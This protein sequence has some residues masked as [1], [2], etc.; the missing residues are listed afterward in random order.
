[1]TLHSTYQ[2]PA[3]VCD[4]DKLSQVAIIQELG[5]LGI[6][7]VALADSPRAIGFGSK[8]LGQRIVCPIPSYDPR[9][10]RFLVSNAPP[11][12]I[13]YSNDANAENVA[14]NAQQ[15]RSS[16]FSL[17]I[18]DS[19]TLER[20]IEKD[21][22][23]QTAL[24]CGIRVPR[25]C[26]VSSAT[27]LEARIDE[28]G[29]PLI[30]KSTNLAGGIYQFVPN[31]ESAAAVFRLMNEIIRGEALRHRE[32][33]LMAQQWV[34]QTDIRLW[35]F[36][37]CVKSGKILSFSMGERIRT[38]TRPD[39]TMGSVLLFGRTAYNPRI[40]EENRRILDHLQ[41]SGLVETEWS[42]STIDAGR[43]YL[44]DF[45]PRPSGNIR[46]ALKSGVSLAEQYYR[47]AL[48]LSPK[49]QVMRTGIVY[50]K[51]LYRQNDFLESATD[52]RVTL[53]RK[54]AVFRDDLMAAIQ[55]HRHAVDVL[56]PRDL[57][58]TWR[59]TA[60]LASILARSI[61]DG[62]HRLTDRRRW[63]LRPVKYESH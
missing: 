2:T 55:C 43:I 1:M 37:A 24:E 17:L 61:R 26:P 51:L 27:E 23:Y 6:P 58:P 50:A 45:N 47:A 31:R 4:A 22:L 7:V 36:N 57:G 40:F 25:C 16:G 32:A 63:H 62:T 3:V 15:L 56:D 21:R 34:P 48:A 18:S 35:N 33:R 41:F 38:D 10:I 14:R 28:F 59:A 49:R 39:G 13:F 5:R 11:G 9:Y 46:W 8:Y 44:Y 52:P 29:L 42:E 12:V 20:V 53:P 30:L 19:E 54:I 60:E